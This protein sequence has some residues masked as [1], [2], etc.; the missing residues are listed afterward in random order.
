MLTAEDILK[1]TNHEMITVPPEAPVIE[2]VRIMAGKQ[3]GAVVV[4]DG[5]AII[6]LFTERDLVRHLARE[7][8]DPKTA[9]LSDH[10]SPCSVFAEHN[11]TI[12]QL[13]DKF[14]GRRCRHLLIRNGDDVLGIL[15]SGDVTRA[16]LNEQTLKLRS[17]SWD[18]YE[19]W[20]WTKK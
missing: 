13:Q 10:M 1:E 16:S 11:E 19:N 7:D 14:L 6:G 5:D 3:I 15:S 20:R 18:Y 17:V 4:R 2:A 9:Q 12:P 8:S